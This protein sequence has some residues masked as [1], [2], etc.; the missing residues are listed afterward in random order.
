LRLCKTLDGSERLVSTF[1]RPR[2]VPRPSGF[3]QIGFLTTLIFFLTQW[4]LPGFDLPALFTL[5]TV[6]ARTDNPTGMTLVG[7]A[8]LVI[9]LRVWRRT[10]RRIRQETTTEVI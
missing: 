2:F 4:V 5:M 6:A 3:A 10:R 1:H 7:L 8:M 9:L